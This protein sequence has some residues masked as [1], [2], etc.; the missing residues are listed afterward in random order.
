MGVY[1]P[2]AMST[3]QVKSEIYKIEDNSQC[4]TEA[5]AKQSLVQDVKNSRVSGSGEFKVPGA[6]HGPK[7]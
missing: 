1:Q 2:H 3:E 5:P 4:H 7:Q 6:H